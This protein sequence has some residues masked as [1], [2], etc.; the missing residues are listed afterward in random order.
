MLDETAV[1]QYLD[2]IDCQ[3]PQCPT[4]EAL[5]EVLDAHLRRIPFANLCTV[6]NNRHVQ[7]MGFVPQTPSLDPNDILEKLTVERW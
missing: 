5:Q 6:H 4:L 7:S 2:Y 1:S 3:H